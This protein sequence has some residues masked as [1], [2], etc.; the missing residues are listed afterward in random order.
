MKLR[1]SGG[2]ENDSATCVGFCPAR[3]TLARKRRGLT[4]IELASLANIDTRSIF[5]YEASE[6]APSEETMISLAR[7][8]KFPVAFFFG[9][10]LDEPRPDTASFRAQSKMSATQRDMALS[11][12]ALALHLNH[13]LEEKFEL[14]QAQLPEL[15]RER[16][17]EAAA[18][19]LRREWGLGNAPVRNIVH[20]FESKGI[21]VFSLSVKAKEVDAFSMWR[22]DTPFMFLNTQ[23][24][25]EHSRFDAAHELGH[26]VLDRHAACQGRES[27]RRAD[28]FASAFLMPRSSVLANVPR[29]STVDQLVELKKIWCV[30]VAALA[31]RYHFLRVLS[32]WH[33]RSIYVEL[34]KRGYSKSEPHPAAHETSQLIAKAFESLREEGIHRHHVAK[35]LLLPVAE[36]DDLL[37]G[38][39]FGKHEGGKTEPDLQSSK[40][41]NL[42]LVK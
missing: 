18:E 19:A 1:S 3:L 13:W 42:T 20:L 16:T 40:R 25:A 4:K 28:A 12:G 38:L 10:P 35:E 23:K 33:Y 26:L 7:A 31:Y 22:G 30:S 24:S 2:P 34:A 15:S 39:T 11:Q 36:L 17:P 27:E 9:E 5:A 6:Y 8:L 21:R 32:D 41:A 37:L 14:P 29:F